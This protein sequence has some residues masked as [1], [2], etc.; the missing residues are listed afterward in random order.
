MLGVYHALVLSRFFENMGSSSVVALYFGMNRLV[1]T[2]TCQ[3]QIAG[4]ID[5]ERVQ[6]E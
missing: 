5:S 4:P 1:F 3:E 2:E 6:W